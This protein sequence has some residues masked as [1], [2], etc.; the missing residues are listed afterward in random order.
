MRTAFSRSSG[1]SITGVWKQDVNLV[2]NS[3]TQRLSLTT[4]DDTVYTYYNGVLQSISYRGGYV[5]TLSYDANG[6]NTGVTDSYGRTLT[7]SY[8]PQ[9]LLQSMTVPGGQV[10]Q[11]TYLGRYDQSVF[12]GVDPSQI[13][14]DKRAL[15]SVIEPAG[16]SGATGNPTVQY[17]YENASFPFALTGII[18]ENGVRFA[19]YTYGT[20]GRVAAEQHAGGVEQNTFSYDDVAG[21]TTIT[22][23][24]SKQAVYY[25]EKDSRGLP[26]LTH[27]AGQPSTNCVASDSYFANNASDFVTDE[28][29][30]EGRVTHY[31]RDARGL[32][33]AVT[34]GYGTASA[35]VTS[36]TWHTTLHVPTQIVD[37]GLTTALTWNPS[38]Q[39]SQVTQTDTTSQTVPYSTNGQTRAWSYTYDAYGNLLTVDGPLAGTGDTVTYTHNSSGFLASVTNEVGQVTTITAWNGRGQPT[40]ITDPNGVARNLAYD[41][42]GRLTSTTVDPTGLSAVTTIA[43]NA[44]GDITQISR[45]NGAYLHYTAAADPG[46]GKHRRVHCLYPRRHGERDSLADQRRQRQPSAVPDR[47]L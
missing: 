5:Q 37:P 19:T 12:S 43:Y 44:V 14:T 39:L 34:R 1:S 30:A 4:A 2:V 26:R 11:Y 31:D 45:P 35:V 18:N 32:P 25:F 41:S 27:I 13:G 15:Q 6:N 40:S 20:D 23:P 21:T 36:Y 24:L 47:S 3:T 7:F 42:L 38:G 29:D 46:S 10:Y 22:N 33:T 16:T 8:G 28:A 17:L 9:G